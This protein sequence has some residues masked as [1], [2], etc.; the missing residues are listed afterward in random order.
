MS[1][2]WNDAQK[3][4]IEG[5]D[6]TML[7][8]AAAGSGKTAVL[9]ERVIRRLTEGENPCGIEDLLIV[10]FTNAAAN[11]MKEKIV[12][13]LQKKIAED[14]S[15]KAL[16]KAVFMLPYANIS[17]IDSF[18]N[19]LVRD[20]YH[21]LGISP[22]FQ[23]LD[24]SR[25]DMLEQKAVMDVIN[26]FHAEREEEFRYL[27]RLLNK[28]RSDEEIIKTV[29]KLYT[30]SRAHTFPGEYLENLLKDY[31]EATPVSETA[32]GKQAL[33][34][35]KKYCEGVLAV[36]DRC[37]NICMSNPNCE[38][39]LVVF[40]DD[41]IKFEGLLDKVYTLEWDTVHEAFSGLKLKG[42]TSKKK[43]DPD[44]KA[45][46][47]SLRNYSTKDASNSVFK[48]LAL[49][50]FSEED[51][52]ES[53]RIIA[54]AVKTLIDTVFAYGE[55]LRAYKDEI[56]SYTFDDI[57]HFALSL[58]VRS[59]NGKPVRTELA[60]QLSENYEEI[61]VDEYQDVNKAQ[62]S[63]FAALSK[64][65]TNRFMVG[66]VKQSI[67][68]FRKAMPEIFT[69]MRKEMADYD[70]VTYPA[71][72][73]LS[74]NYRSRKGVTDTVNFIFSQLMTEQTGGVDYDEREKLIPE[75][76]YPESDEPC[77]E[78]YLLE[79]D[80]KDAQAAFAANYIRNAVENE[81]QISDG[82]KMRPARYGDFCILARDN[83]SA[84][85]FSE[86]F[87][88][89][90]VPLIVDAG[91]NLLETPEVSFLVSLL[92]VI[93]NPLL[94]VPLTAVMLSPVYGF[95]TDEISE[96]R[97]GLRKGSIYR[98]LCK[99]A[100][101]GSEKAAKFIKEL[102][103]LRR[104]AVNLP[105]SEFTERIIEE[106]G[107]RAIVSAMENSENRLAFVEKFLGLAQSYESSG[108]KGISAFVRFLDSAG[109][110]GTSIEVSSN[111]TDISD[112]VTMSTIHKSKGL[113]Y[114]VVLLCRCEKEYN[115]QS[116]KD[117]L[118]VAENSGIGLKY[119]LDGVTS[120][121]F[122][123]ECVENEIKLKERSEE[124]RVLYVALTRAKEK[125]IITASDK[126]WTSALKKSAGCVAQGINPSPVAVAGMNSY[127]QVILT[128]LLKHPDAHVLR[129]LVNMSP[130]VCEKCDSRI[131]FEIL[132]DSPEDEGT[133]EA[134]QE[135]FE[136]D[137]ALLSR[138]SEKLAYA[139]PYD[140][141]GN[142]IA[143][144]IA[145]DFE[146][147]GFDMTYFASEV[148]GF[149][150]K[151]GLTPA[152]KGTAT[153]RFMQYADYR[154]AAKDPGSELERLV[155]E[156]LL[157]PEEAAGVDRDSIRKFFTSSIADRIFA[158]PEDKVFKEYAFTVSLPLSEVYPGISG[159]TAKDEVIIIEGVADLAFIEDGKLVIV[160]YK[161]DRAN[162]L[163]ELAVRYAP[164]L[165]TYRKC[166]S[167]AFGMEV[168]ETLIYSFR[169]G[170]QIEIK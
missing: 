142:V 117:R 53:T 156:Y 98:C 132:K 133:Y 139:Y 26:R 97:I 41:K 109:Q 105:A 138:V 122:R 19:A 150:S 43:I 75:A 47:Q 68:G 116:T 49:F 39:T 28:S 144:R 67:Y 88:N 27:N 24:N 110:N 163:A 58:L 89:A 167:Q 84:K 79:T 151:G 95:T 10:T 147:E 71:R 91:S 13:A 64:D 130:S 159:D 146:D 54:P 55:T 162:S 166:L 37:I 140:E 125:L 115:N 52:M 118:I 38:N 48:K 3:H 96:M 131:I 77:T 123:R 81:M 113:E 165:T 31:E 61:L 153:H 168:K 94:D 107:Y 155:S 103:K 33:E 66:D 106:T 82:E 136:A 30:I 6:G 36:V 99:S 4:A 129:N 145:S 72:V 16:R 35:A 32:Q 112:A 83:K 15:N 20:S 18:C 22:D 93:D 34:G 161:T 157:T 40:E 102:E 25:K 42:F 114:P 104:I 152:Q 5:R 17:T 69:S 100:E 120:E 21:T 76:K 119:S 141:L 1:I 8:S 50:R 148:P 78:V 143:K 63:I 135:H 124:L 73:D 7:V 45:L 87:R 65:N 111:L 29:K 158:L 56:N 126:D 121:N 44:L 149:V 128:A 80:E 12:S 60:A 70:G 86:V 154:K 101:S 2:K 74:A 57:M 92:K 170:A 62:D 11:Q 169:L 59:E 14:P 134:P 108:V 160:D 23:I 85:T 9:V 46:L 127:S 51:Y 164:Q 90:R 137:P